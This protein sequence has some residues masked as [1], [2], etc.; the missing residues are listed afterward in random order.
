MNIGHKIL[1]FSGTG[2][3]TVVLF[4][5]AALADGLVITGFFLSDPH[6]GSD[7][8]IEHRAAVNARRIRNG[9][10]NDFVE[11]PIG[12]R[13]A[14]T[15]V[16]AGTGKAAVMIGSIGSEVIAHLRLESVPDGEVVGSDVVAIPEVVPAFRLGGLGCLMGSEAKS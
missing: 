6:S 16:E 7:L 1:L 8:Q 5:G 14:K 10:N 15:E 11:F 2:L 13:S 9:S 12:D 3:L 4:I